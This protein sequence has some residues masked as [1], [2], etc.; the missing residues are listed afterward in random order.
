MGHS[1]IQFPLVAHEQGPDLFIGNEI[2]RS[3]WILLLGLEHIV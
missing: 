1:L 2:W 3:G